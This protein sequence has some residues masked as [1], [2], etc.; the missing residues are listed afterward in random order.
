MVIRR[1]EVRLLGLHLVEPFAAAHGVM[2][3]RRPLAVVR[4]DADEGS[5]W[6]ECEALPQAGYTPEWAA[7]AFA[8]MRDV[9]APRLLGADPSPASVLASLSAAAPAHPMAVAALELAVLDLVLRSEGRTLAEQLGPGRRSVTAGAV[10]GL[11][12]DVGSLVARVEQLVSAGYRR[13]KVKIQPGWDVEPL[14]ALRATFPTLE[15]Q[16][17]ANGSYRPD[18]R[19]TLTALDPVGLT[20]L[21][22]PLPAHDLDG[23]RRLRAG[24]GIPLGLDESV[25]TLPALDAVLRA[26]AADVVVIKPARLGGL[27]A[28]MDGHDRCVEAGVAVMAGGLLEAGLG[29]RALAAVAALPGFTVTGDVAPADRWLVDDPWPAMPM[30]DGEVAVHDGPGVAPLPDDDRL[31]ATTLERAI[32]GERLDP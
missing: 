15:L 19:R 23:A 16:A 2:T 14:R 28:A 1:V 32:V 25:A 9:L 26:A 5:G 18:D 20:C 29:R 31:E 11:G 10:V 8:T 22:Q 3:D 12:S 21:E 13:V 6:G 4:V 24:V 7:G 30:L 17:D 27:A